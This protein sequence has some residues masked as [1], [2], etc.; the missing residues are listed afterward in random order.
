MRPLG[1]LV[2][3]LSG[4]AGLTW[5]VV[6][7]RLLT[8]V[9]GSTVHAVSVVTALFLLGLGAGAWLASRRPVSRPVRAYAV[10]EVGVALWGLS[11]AFALPQLE[12]AIV[13]GVVVGP[14]GWFTPA[15]GGQLARYGLAALALAPPTLAMGATLPLLL[16][17]L[18]RGADLGRDVGWLVAANTAGAALGAV[19]TDLWWVPT[20]GLTGTQGLAALANGVA[21][22]LA[23]WGLSGEAGG[24]EVVA[25]APAAP[26]AGV[27]L[28]LTGLAA[29]GLEVLW[30]RFLGS[31]L[32]PYRATFAL[33]LGVLL[34]GLLAGSLL[35]ARLSRRPWTA[36]AL[37]QAGVA[38]LSLYGL[39]SHDAE[40]LLRLQLAGGSQ[41]WV[42]TL[43]VGW[44]VLPTAVCMGLSLPLASALAWRGRDGASQAGALYAAQTVGN[45]AGALLV[46]FWM[47]PALGMQ[48]TA[49]VLATLASVAPLVL[50]PSRTWPAT[51]GLGAVLLGLLQP[52]GTLVTQ[53]FPANLLDTQPVLALVEG[54]E[55]T[56]AVTG[57]L[58]GPARLWTGGHPMTST[59]LH[60]QRYMRL[61]AHLPLL[62]QEA[63]ERALVIA[64]GVGNTSDAARLHGVQLDVVDRSPD[65]LALAPFFAHANHDV[66]DVAR[67]FVDDGRRHLHRDGPDYDVI[68]LE[69]PP[70]GA[71][72]VSALYSREFYALARERLVEGG[73]LAQWLPA[74]QVPEASVSALVAAFVAV[75]PDATLHLGSGREL[76]LLGTNGA[77]HIDRATLAR[78]LAARPEVADDLARVG[79]P[80]ADEL[81]TTVVADGATLIAA[82]EGV[83]PLSDD[84]PVVEHTQRNHVMETRLPAALFAPGA[85]RWCVDCEVLAPRRAIL[86]DLVGTEEFLAYSNVA[87]STTH[88]FE[89]PPSTPTDTVATSPFLCAIFGWV[90]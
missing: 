47:L 11:L 8:R 29:M 27:A 80:T 38:T 65:I 57:S 37:A 25:E 75:F 85:S 54:A 23:W 19:A 68:T 83:T 70:I 7:V 58:E 67:V 43:V 26:R 50:D 22:A 18:H 52:S 62:T 79:F 24:T 61:M 1:L 15:L 31:A 5:Q 66:L 60:A 44:V 82:V 33:L 48:A 21:A 28:L 84:R 9:L 56:L 16:S 20:L 45:V 34:V 41:T 4:A 13:G 6:W 89:M 55:E 71:A 69:P 63:P 88:A 35:G 3:A 12:G 77:H 59:T 81:L 39:F 72:G 78:R 74:Y 36:W 14:S 64:F 53:S 46:G 40:W 51:L 76:V 42:D 30:F 87:G 32:G 86:D 49:L 2:F 17:R 73:A 90:R 10:L